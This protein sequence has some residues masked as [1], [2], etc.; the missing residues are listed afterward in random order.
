MKCSKVMSN[1]I[2]QILQ[3]RGDIQGTNTFFHPQEKLPQEAKVTYRCIVCDILPQKKETHRVQLKLGGYKINFDRPVPNPTS[4]LTNSKLH[5]N[6]AVSTQGAKYLVVDVKNFYLNY[7]MLKHEYHKIALIL[8]PQ[9]IIDNYNLTNKKI[10]V[11]I[12]VRV[13]NGMYGLF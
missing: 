12:Y 5:W 3:G 4:N 7:L 10:N 13:E 1:E 11:L 6:S 9:D 8:I 2:I